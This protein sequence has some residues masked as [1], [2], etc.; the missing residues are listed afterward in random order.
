M[1]YSSKVIIYLPLAISAHTLIFNVY[2]NFIFKQVG[3]SFFWYALFFNANISIQYALVSHLYLPVVLQDAQCILR[4]CV[5]RYF[6]QNWV[7]RNSMLSLAWP[8]NYCQW[9]RMFSYLNDNRFLVSLIVFLMLTNGNRQLH[10]HEGV[11]RK[12]LNLIWY[13]SIHFKIQRRMGLT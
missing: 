8:N 13:G 7:L 3:S 4:W 1:K 6:G 5:A 9:R 11:L 2:L 10:L 12:N